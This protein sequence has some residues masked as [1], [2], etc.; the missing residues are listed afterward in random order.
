MK[1]VIDGKS[2][3]TETAK[4]LAHASWGSPS[5]FHHWDE[6]LYRTRK[7]AF[8]IA[9]GGGPMTRWAR[10]TGNGN[11]RSGS[12]GIRVLSEDEAREWIERH[13]NDQYEAV[14]GPVPEA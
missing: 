5:D 14:F 2:Y 8:F 3:N 13:A 4:E 6:T 11:E 7:G 10:S 9:G 1:Q 12:T